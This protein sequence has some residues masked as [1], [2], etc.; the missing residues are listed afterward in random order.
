MIPDIDLKRLQE[1]GVP[2]DP[3][4]VA[5]L[6]RFVDTL[7]GRIAEISCLASESPQEVARQLHQL[8]GSAANC[9]FTALEQFCRQ[10]GS[11]L[12][13]GE[14]AALAERATESWTQLMDNLNPRS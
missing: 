8:A 5:I 10:S 12:N 4:V 1:I 9:G 14:L 11:E 2:G 13:P 3:A 6:Q 7:K